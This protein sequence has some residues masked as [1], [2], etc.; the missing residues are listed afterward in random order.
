VIEISS[1][2]NLNYSNA[3]FLINESLF[4]EIE[5]DLLKNPKLIRDISFKSNWS[6]IITNG[7][8]I[9]GLGDIGALAGLPVMEGKSTIF[10]QLGG[11]DCIP[12]CIQEKNPKKLIS[13][14]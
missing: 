2:I 3:S 10:K 5:Q 13:L 11:V 6:G 8:S 1:K 4:D 12:I 14:V 9:L 7:T